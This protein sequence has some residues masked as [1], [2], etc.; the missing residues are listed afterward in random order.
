MIYTGYYSNKSK[1]ESKGFFTIGISSY[2]PNYIDEDTPLYR[3]IAPNKQMV[4][5]LHAGDRERFIDMFSS[6]L[7]KLDVNNTINELYSL[8]EGQDIILLC[9]E[10]P[11]KFCHRHLVSEWLTCNGEPVSELIIHKK[12]DMEQCEIVL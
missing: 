11:N 2:L 6:K 12:G 1:Y 3:K 8:S 7:N 4:D 9:F 10:S 5:I